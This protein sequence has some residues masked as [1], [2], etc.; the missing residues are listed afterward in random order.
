L[1][2]EQ[3]VSEMVVEVLARR[4]EALSEGTERSFEDAFA[5]VLDTPAGRLLGELAEG[6]QRHERAAYWQA[7][8]R[9]ERE[10]MRPA[11]LLGG[12]A[13]ST[14]DRRRTR[15]RGT[16]KRL[17]LVEDNEAFREAF[18][19]M[20]ELELA[21]DLDVAFA[22]ADSLAE[23]HA[24]LK[25]EYA[26]DAVLIDVGLPDGDGLD[27]VRELE[28]DGGGIESLPTLVITANLERS[29]ASRAMEAGAR[30]VLSKVVSSR[31]TAEAVRML[32]GAGHPTG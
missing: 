6:P 5:E 30:G 18:A 8:L 27:L 4:A 29:V 16:Q 15:G 22:Q 31:E 14:D 7:R 17:L 1:R 28:E 32:I 24:L 9:A 10:A 2:A 20:L 11:A 23:A 26:L 3:T 13:T 19:R 21:P 25:E 12:E